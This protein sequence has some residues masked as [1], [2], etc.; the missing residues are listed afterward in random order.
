MAANRNKKHEINQRPLRY[1]ERPPFGRSDSDSVVYH[2][3]PAYATI[4]T[5]SDNIDVIRLNIYCIRIDR[6]IHQFYHAV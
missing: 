2:E 5:I 6:F 3:A 1:A 4:L